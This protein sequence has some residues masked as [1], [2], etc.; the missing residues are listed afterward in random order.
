MWAMPVRKGGWCISTSVGIS[1]FWASVVVEPAQAFR[2]QLAAAL[3]GDDRIE[4]DEA[5]RPALDGVVQEA[6]R[7]ADSPCAAN[8]RAHRLALVVVAGDGKDRRAA[9]APGSP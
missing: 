2:A 8:G 4:A 3:A 5:Q 9:A 7:P 1:G 6:V